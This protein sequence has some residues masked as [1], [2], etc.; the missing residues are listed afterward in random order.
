MSTA[1]ST[2]EE[3]YAEQEAILERISRCQD[4]LGSA[5]L[6]ARV[7][8]GI[9][10]TAKAFFTGQ[11]SWAKRGAIAP[12]PARRPQAAVAPAPVIAPPAPVVTP[13]VVAAPAPVP[14]P[15]VVET[16]PPPVK[17]DAPETLAK[18]KA[19]T[20]F[21]AEVTWTA[22]AAGAAPVAKPAKP[23]LAGQLL[24]GQETPALPPPPVVVARPAPPPVD[25]TVPAGAF[26]RDVPWQPGQAPALGT[27]SNFLATATE[28]ALR[29]A[30]R[31]ATK[32]A[33]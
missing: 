12:Q 11:V 13:V 25:Y 26:F 17:R 30:Q 2:P 1:Y 7:A 8:L 20:F 5:I 3:L 6:R 4:I 14:A 21:R 22:R 27:G 33:P 31:L 32:P 18:F 15:V 16:G 29:A 19:G 9:E 10:P 28:S 24:M 23:S